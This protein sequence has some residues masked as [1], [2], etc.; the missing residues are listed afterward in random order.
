MV[1]CVS[2]FSRTPQGHHGN[3]INEHQHTAPNTIPI[4]PLFLLVAAFIKQHQY[5]I[6]VY[7]LINV[8]GISESF[9][10]ILFSSFVHFGVGSATMGPVVL[11]P[12]SD[13]TSAFHGR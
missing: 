4:P 7:L 6:S 13:A 11:G 8:T 2:I 1:S 5:L 12:L 10:G 3:S 9:L